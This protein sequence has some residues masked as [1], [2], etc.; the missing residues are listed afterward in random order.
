PPGFP[1]FVDNAEYF[2]NVVIKQ[3][4]RER[5]FHMVPRKISLQFHQI[6]RPPGTKEGVLSAPLHKSSGCLWKG[7]LIGQIL[8]LKGNNFPGPPVQRPVDYRA[9]YFMKMICDFMLFIHFYSA[10]LN[11]F[12]GEKMLLFFFSLRTLVPFQIQN[13]VVHTVSSG[14]SQTAVFLL[15]LPH[16]I[17]NVQ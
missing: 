11:D 4:K 10:D 12:K 9:D 17:L 13:N 1:V 15:L 6:S 5:I 16:F 14:G 7:A 8:F 3:G 2:L